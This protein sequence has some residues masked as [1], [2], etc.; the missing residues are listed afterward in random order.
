MLWISLRRVVNISSTPSPVLAEHSTYF[1]LCFSAKAYSRI[2]KY[3]ALSLVNYPLIIQVD[4]ICYKHVSHE[5]VPVVL[6]LLVE[7]SK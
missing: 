4:F 3:L 7:K 1:N 2:A 5:V 6:D